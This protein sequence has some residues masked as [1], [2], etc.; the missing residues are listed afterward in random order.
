MS[1]VTGNGKPIR[2]NTSITLIKEQLKTQM[3]K[4]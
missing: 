1:T 4:V 3:I 2:H